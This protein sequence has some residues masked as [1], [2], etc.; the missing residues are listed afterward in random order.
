MQN[1]A[2]IEIR[3]HFGEVLDRVANGE[4]IGVTREGRQ[5]ATIVPS[6]DEPSAR[7]S[8]TG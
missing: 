5:V 4:T 7:K 1:M 8:L 2:E 3:D 6:I